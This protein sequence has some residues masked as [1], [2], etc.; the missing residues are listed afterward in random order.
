MSEIFASTAFHTLKKTLNKIHMDKSDGYESGLVYP[1]WCEKTT[2]EDA[3][4]D[5]LE[6][7][8]PGLASETPE[9]TEIPVGSVTQGNLIRYFSRKFG[10][11]LIITEEAME[12]SKYKEILNAARMLKRSM[13]KTMDIDATLMLAR[14]FNSAYAYADGQPLWSTSHT[15]PKGGTYSNKLAVAMSPSRAAVIAVTSM[16]RKLPGMDGIVE[17]Y[18]IEKVGC[19]TEQWAAWEGIVKSEKAPEAGMFNEINVA[20]SVVKGVVPIKYWSNTTTNWFVTTDCDGGPNV[21][22]RRA[23]KT[24][25]WVENSNEIALHSISARWARGCSNFRSTIGVEA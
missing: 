1:K 18:E 4:E 3:Y 21:R 20:R 8:G 24:R 22:I 7:A 17:G 16:A 2:M 13:Y 14:G 6:F 25:T 9:G 19:P 5:D 12:D 10:L 15:L 11:R 23:P